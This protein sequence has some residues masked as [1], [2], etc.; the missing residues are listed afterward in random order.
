LTDPEKRKKYDCGQMDFDGDVGT[1]GFENMGQHF[2]MGNAGNMGNVKFTFNGT[3][4]SGMG[5]D[6]SQIFSMF[7]NKGGGAGGFEDFEGFGFGGGAQKQGQ[8]KRG[9]SRPKGFPGFAGFSNFGE[10]GSNFNFSWYFN[11]IFVT[12]LLNHCSLRTVLYYIFDE[13]Y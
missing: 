9:S 6:P 8:N 2:N 1:E 3:D 13:Y 12:Y 7:L 4:M 11:F 10:K 5:I